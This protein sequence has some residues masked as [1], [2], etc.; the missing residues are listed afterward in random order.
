MNQEFVATE[1]KY[2]MV[3]EEV[4]ENIKSTPTW[5]IDDVYLCSGNSPERKTPCGPSPSKLKS[6]ASDLRV[7]EAN[8]SE[9]EE[10]S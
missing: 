8:S 6:A 10:A 2:S 5:N 1:I 7:Q 9:D 4:I 3:Y